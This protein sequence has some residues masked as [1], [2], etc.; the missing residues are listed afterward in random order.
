MIMRLL[1]ITILLLFNVCGEIIN[2]QE[3]TTTYFNKIYSLDLKHISFLGNEIIDDHIYISSLMQKSDTVTG[4][5]IAKADF[6]GNLIWL[7]QLNNIKSGYISYSLPKAFYKDAADNNFYLSGTIG[8]NS[9]DTDIL[10]LKIN[11]NGDTIYTHLFNRPKKSEGSSTILKADSTG[12]SVVCWSSAPGGYSKLI[13]LQTDK[14]GNELPTIELNTIK[15]RTIL[16]S[17]PTLDGGYILSGYSYTIEKGFDMYALKLTANF[18]TEWEKTWGTTENDWGCFALQIS[19]GEYIILGAKQIGSKDQFYF[20]RLDK[21]GNTLKTKLYPFN[22]VCGADGSVVLMPNDDVIASVVDFSNTDTMRTQLT[23]FTKDG[24]IVW[25]SQLKTGIG[26]ED[27]IRDIERT[28]DGGF[29]LSGFNHLS[30]VTAWLVKT[31]SMGK[32]CGIANCDTTVIL[33]SNNNNI[34]ANKPYNRGINNMQIT[35][36]AA[37]N[38]INLQATIPLHLPYTVFSLYNL[39]GQKVYTS[40]PIF[41]NQTNG[42]TAIDLVLPTSLP[43]GAYI[44]QLASGIGVVAS[45]KLLIID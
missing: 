39:Q 21:D 31:D 19:N 30:P 28:P 8:K 41:T 45:G 11:T 1:L 6:A 36:H 7:K 18:E 24:E 37:G 44:G 33:S 9:V 3:P 35:H 43:A 25:Q 29:I 27:Y 10:L 14:N 22:D 34:T 32:T 16:Y 13:I 20:A 5:A 15:Y 42:I 38:S 2:A 4:F 26:F 17:Q 40:K 12:C 23:R